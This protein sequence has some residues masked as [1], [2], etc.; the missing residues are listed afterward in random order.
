MDVPDEEMNRL[1][2]E[3]A[4]AE[5]GIDPDV[6]VAPVSVSSSKTVIGTGKRTS[7]P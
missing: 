6:L 4:A 7:R 2:L 5:V 3:A 1:W